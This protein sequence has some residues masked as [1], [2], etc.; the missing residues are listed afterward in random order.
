MQAAPHACKPQGERECDD[1]A[2]RV[3][4]HCLPAIG[5]Q[6]HL[7]TD[8]YVATEDVRPPI[9]VLGGCAAGDWDIDTIKLKSGGGTYEK[10]LSADE[11]TLA[12]VKAAC[13][14]IDERMSAYEADLS[15]FQ[16]KLEGL[17]ERMMAAETEYA[18]RAL[19]NP[20]KR[21]P[22]CLGL[23][24]S[25]RDADAMK[26]LVP[27]RCSIVQV[28]LVATNHVSAQRDVLGPWCGVVR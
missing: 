2:C 7:E 9:D 12:E 16:T 23:S 8:V 26:L 19:L 4:G 28:C 24:G 10:D 11:K 27:A 20:C 17:T 25:S 6:K 1:G 5:A 14:I 18:V 22:L 13:M 21:V 3:G 15:S